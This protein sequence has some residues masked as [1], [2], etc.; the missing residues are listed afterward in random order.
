MAKIQVMGPGCKRCATLYENVKAAVEE[1]GGDAEVEKVT[2][3]MEMIKLGIMSTPVLVVDG[4][5]RS[6]GR[7]L[8]KNEIKSIIA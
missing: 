8:D 7:V 2:D 6:T 4:T 1:L 3:T 5:V